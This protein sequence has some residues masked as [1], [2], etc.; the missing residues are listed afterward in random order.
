MYGREIQRLYVDEAAC[1]AEK[2]RKQWESQFTFLQ[3]RV[4]DKFNLFFFNN[5][6]GKIQLRAEGKK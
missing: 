6:Q 2:I 4:S 3:Y 1:E 5:T